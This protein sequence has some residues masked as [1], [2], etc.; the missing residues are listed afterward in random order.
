MKKFFLLATFSTALLLATNTT[1]TAQQAAIAGAE[2]ANKSGIDW[3]TLNTYEHV[4]SNN[5]LNIIRSGTHVLS[6]KSS[7]SV[8]VNTDGNVRLILN[9][10]DI[11]SSAGAAIYIENTDNTVIELASSSQNTLEDAKTR[12]DKAINGAL[13][14]SDDLMFQGAGKL[15]IKANFQDGIVSKDDLDFFS[16]EYNI[17]SVDDGIHGKDSLTIEGGIISVVAKGDGI[18]S[19]NEDDPEKGSIYINGGSTTIYSGDDGIAAINNIVVNDGQIKVLNSIEGMEASTITINDGDIRVVARD[20]GI[21][22]VN[23]NRLGNMSITV[24]GGNIDVTVGR[25]DTD[26]FD[27]NGTILITGGNI[28]VTAPTSSFDSS[29]G[30]EMTGGTL[31]VNGELLTELPAER[32]G[33]RNGMG[34][35]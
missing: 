33:G 26:A 32:R 31:V 2:T 10:V 34:R 35:N 18:K 24:N 3:S 21:N 6:G 29:R 30:S 27:S 13:Y 17:S 23:D 19:S 11:R 14:S 15:N 1:V 4:L 16:G 22:A 12:N 9:G 8:N 5:A 20:D 25:G 7:A 28:N